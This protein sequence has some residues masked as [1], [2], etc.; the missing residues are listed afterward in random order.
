MSII[1]RWLLII[2]GLVMGYIII[3]YAYDKA[4]PDEVKLV[5]EIKKRR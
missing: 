4:R 1:I 2:A 5:K 3:S